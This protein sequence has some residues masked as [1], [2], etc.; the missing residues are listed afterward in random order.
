MY[1]SYDVFAQKRD[2]QMLAM[3]SVVLLEVDRLTPAQRKP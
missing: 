3:L 2:L 1:F